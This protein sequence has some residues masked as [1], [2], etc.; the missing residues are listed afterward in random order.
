MWRGGDH[1][2]QIVRRRRTDEHRW[3]TDGITGDLVEDLARYLPDE[4]IAGLLDRP[5]K[6]AGKG[7]SWTKLWACS[8]RSSRGVAAYRKGE[9]QERAEL[10]PS[11]AAERLSVD[12][13]R[14]R[15][16]HPCCGTP[17]G[18]ASRPRRH[19]TP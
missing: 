18:T 15:M 4:L 9:R 8:F 10:I 19:P 14:E 3:S 17:P 1:T 12:P 2:E 7:N 16:R 6:T 5:G 11:E 13:E